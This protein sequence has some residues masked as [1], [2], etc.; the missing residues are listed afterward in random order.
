MARTLTP[1]R[2]PGKNHFVLDIDVIGPNGA[3]KRTACGLETDDKDE[4][5][6]IAH[7]YARILERPDLTGDPANHIHDLTSYKLKAVELA[8]GKNHSALL[9]IKSMSD[10]T[11]G[12][13]QAYFDELQ[14][15][16]LE[17]PRVKAARKEIE[18]V[19]RKSPCSASVSAA[20]T[21]IGISGRTNSGTQLA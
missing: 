10:P 7:D 21:T 16:L 5:D 14:R 12:L 1:R 13:T 15:K 6:T 19:A 4:A 18:E 9:K 20:A 17:I 2:Q 11:I 8:L 3:K